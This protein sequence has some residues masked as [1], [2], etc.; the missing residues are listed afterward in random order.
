L[1]R[2]GVGL[3]IISK[4]KLTRILDGGFIHVLELLECIRAFAANN[5]AAM[6]KKQIAKR[7]A[8]P[9]FKPKAVNK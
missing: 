8:Y 1:F 2:L 6:S 3:W 9:S 4:D 7:L 5:I